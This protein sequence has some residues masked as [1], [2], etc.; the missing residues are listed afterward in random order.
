M[1][2]K[3]IA[4]G[5]AAGSLAC[6]D[7]PTEIRPDVCDDS[8]DPPRPECEWRGEIAPGKRIEVVGING[9]IEASLVEGDEVI[10]S[11][12]KRGIHHDPS[13]VTIEVVTHDDGVT[14]CAVYPSASGA[15]PNECHPDGGGNHDV[16]D[17]DVEVT[18]TVSVP[19]GV[20]F[21][22]R[23]VTGD[24]KAEGLMSDAFVSTVTGDVTVSTSGLAIGSSVT[25]SVYAS[26]GQP[27]WD[28]DLVFCTVTGSVTVE[29]P[30]STNADVV[31]TAVTGGV[32][33]DFPLSKDWAGVWRGTVGSGGRTLT[34][35]TVT[36]SVRLRRGS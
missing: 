17:T 2:M 29:I 33:S 10:V 34:A 4:I 11:W 31:A 32:Y 35:A 6:S 19:R 14:I 25:G 26:I 16:R 22:G 3:L 15:P 5:V 36:G 13:E 30:S 27:D 8:T 28:R 1:R 7:Y 23:L 18:F 12:V 24:V 9:D 20:H 21:Y